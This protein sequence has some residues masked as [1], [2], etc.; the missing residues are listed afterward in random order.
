MC[1]AK[2]VLGTNFTVYLN[3]FYKKLDI[4]IFIVFTMIL[5]KDGSDVKV[6]HF[7]NI[8]LTYEDSINHRGH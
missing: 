5:S 3:H 1:T 8:K 4:K 6:L 7:L 2:P